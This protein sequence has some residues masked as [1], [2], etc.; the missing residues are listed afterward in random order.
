[1][2]PFIAFLGFT[3][4]AAGTVW[5]AS[6]AK[7]LHFSVWW[8]VGQAVSLLAGSLV[9]FT[10]GPWLFSLWHVAGWGDLT[11]GATPLSAYFLLVTALVFVAVFVYSPAYLEHYRATHNIRALLLILHLT[12]FS[13]ALVFWAENVV[14]FL[15]AW[16]IMS[17]LSYLLVTFDYRNPAS[18]RAA[19]VMLGASEAGFLAM[20]AAWLPL[21]LMSHSISFA[22][23]HR[24]SSGSLF[25]SVRWTVLLLSLVGFG[26]K[27]G[28]APSMSWLPRAHPAAPANA[29]AVLSGVIL[30]QGIY[31]IVLTNAVL[32]PVT[33]PVGG[34][35]VLGIGSISALIGIIYAATDNQMKRMLA[36]SS[37]ENMGLVTTAIGAALTFDALHLPILA[38]LAWVAAFYHLLNHSVYKSLLFLGAGALD[39]TAHTLD[40]DQLGGLSRRLP[41]TAGF[42]LV[43]TMAIAALPPF[44]GFVSEWLIIQSLLRS[45]D[46]GSAALEVFYG[47]SAVLVA[48]TAGLATTAFVRFYGMTFLGR[49][50]SVAAEAAHEVSPSIRWAMGFLAAVCFLLGVIPTYVVVGLS[51]LAEPLT[52]HFGLPALVPPFFTPA[53]LPA[54]FAATFQALG[55]E[56]G[57][58]LLP[59]PGLV[60][61]HQTTRPSPHVVFAMAPSYLI[62]IMVLALIAVYV[63][64]R[65]LL[66]VRRVTRIKPWNGGA[67]K[68][69]PGMGYTATGLANPIRVIFRAILNPGQAVDREEVVAR[70]FQTAISR[71]IRE[72]YVMDRWLFYPLAAAA[73]GFAR[74]LAKMHHGSINAYIAYA[75]LT[76]LA[77]LI[78]VRFF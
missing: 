56:I 7:A 67:N 6:P 29:S 75:F 64:L 78:L 15:L 37:I 77:A 30:N 61:M 36:H 44:N 59:L 57:R 48:L 1:M 10:Q 2:L 46:L 71:Q 53:R 62:I 60:L 38:D 54:S 41:W 69:D 33:I 42:M 3:A 13:I 24:L 26:V 74:L 18:S 76:L 40:M 11:I 27:A 21:V 32:L 17:V 72:S 20:V 19:Y 9:V 31:G 28:L 70:H 65:V 52:G 39:V 25:D 63:G 73:D 66:P 12:L 5:L 50:R 58:S 49:A 68:L 4:L 8:G 16:E 47:L 35:V 34:L 22:V 43:G 23:I 51:R 45:V 14:G 55:A